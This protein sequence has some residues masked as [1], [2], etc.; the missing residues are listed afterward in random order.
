M[1]AELDTRPCMHRV[2]T[3]H[4]MNSAFQSALVLQILSF[5]VSLNTLHQPKIWN[6]TA[7]STPSY[8]FQ[9]STLMHIDFSFTT[10]WGIFMCTRTFLSITKLLLRLFLLTQILGGYTLRYDFP[11]RLGRQYCYGTQKWP[12]KHS[13]R[14]PTTDEDEAVDGTNSLLELRWPLANSSHFSAATSCKYN[15]HVFHAS[16]HLPRYQVTIFSLP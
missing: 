9:N 8:L 13:F 5:G 15:A 14:G 12:L 1:C 10:S 16:P 7:H 4:R 11:W 6:M 2:I 3:V